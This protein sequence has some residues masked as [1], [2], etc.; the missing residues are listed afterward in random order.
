MRPAAGCTDPNWVGTQRRTQLHP[1]VELKYL[2]NHEM[3]GEEA[4]ACSW[5]HSA[6]CSMSSSLTHY[7]CVELPQA[8]AQMLDSDNYTNENP[9]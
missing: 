6:T 7:S 9:G 4:S 1:R 2:H 5:Q 8:A 3:Y